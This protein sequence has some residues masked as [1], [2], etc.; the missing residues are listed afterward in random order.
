MDK[1]IAVAMAAV[2]AKALLDRVWDFLPI[3]TTFALACWAMWNGTPLGAYIAAGYGIFAYF[4][5]RHIRGDRDG[6]GQQAGA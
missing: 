1:E 5:G 3:V 2:T 6:K 4:W